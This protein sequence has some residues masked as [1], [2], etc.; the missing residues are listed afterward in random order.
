LQGRLLRA[1]A[2]DE[3]ARQ[4]LREARALFDR[5]GLADEADKTRV[6]LDAP[7]A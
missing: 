1:R 7:S 4:A 2:E 6:L 5:M 3:Q